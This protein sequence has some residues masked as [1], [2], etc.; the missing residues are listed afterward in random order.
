[1]GD[2]NARVGRRV[3]DSSDFG[4]YSS[5]IVGPWSLK[6]DLVPNLNGGLL[7]DVA[8]EFGLRMFSLTTHVRTLSVGLGDTRNIEHVL[9]LI[10]Y[11]FRLPT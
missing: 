1:M 4:A 11:S 2:F 10:T 5:N 6:Y 3:E 7:L 9:C 8:S